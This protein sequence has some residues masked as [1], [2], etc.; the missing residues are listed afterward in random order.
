[1]S[2]LRLVDLGPL[3]LESFLKLS[4]TKEMVKGFE[5]NVVWLLFENSF[6]QAE[7]M[8]PSSR[9]AS[10]TLSTVVPVASATAFV[11]SLVPIPISSS[12]QAGNMVPKIS[13]PTCSKVSSSKSLIKSTII[14]VFSNLLVVSSKAE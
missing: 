1:M 14:S 5:K 12:L 13:K 11:T 9:T 3:I 10:S 6:T 2:I 4:K 7:P 8:S